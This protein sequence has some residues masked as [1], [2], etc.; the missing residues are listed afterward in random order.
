MPHYLLLLAAFCGLYAPTLRA[1]GLG[2]DAARASVNN[3]SITEF[4]AD[5]NPP[6]GLPDEEYVELYNPSDSTVSLVG[7][8]LGSGGR[9]VALRG[10]IAPRSYL[11]L[12]KPGAAPFFTRLGVE[13]LPIALPGLTNGGD[14]V[15]LIAFGDTLLSIDYTDTWYNDPERDR[16]G[17]SLEYT[18]LS[19]ADAGCSGRWKASNDPK[20][21]TPGAANSVLG[22][23]VDSTAP[24]VVSTNLTATHISVGFNEVLTTT[25]PDFLLL[26]GPNEVPILSIETYDGGQS[27]RLGVSDSIREGVFY[28]LIIPS[29]SDCAGNTS[30]ERTI[31]VGSPSSPRPGDVI[32]NELL[33]DPVT[34]GSD[35]LEL[36]NRTDKVFQINGWRLTNRQSVSNATRVVTTD[37]LFLPGEYLI[38]TEDPDDL[39][40][41]FTD[42]VPSF[43]VEQALPGLPN[44]G[45]N[46]TVTAAGVVLDAFDYSDDLHS[47]LL[48]DTDGVSLERL[49]TGVPTQSAANWFSAA[50]GVGGG[51]PTR[52]NSQDRPAA[53]PVE[54][55][56][57]S[58]V[59]T[60]FSPDGDGFEDLLEI[61][62]RAVAIGTVARV[63]IYDAQGRSV[64][65]LRDAE[66]LGTEGTMTWDG[67]DDDGLKARVGIYVVVVELSNPQG[68]AR[69]EKLVAVL[70]GDR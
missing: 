13:V 60:T 26:D 69:E 66:L 28:D 39:A 47:E 31:S 35:Y 6:V 58:V 10:Q 54:G 37:R 30:D 33:Y 23:A 61:R 65:T 18:E 52:P 7:V 17:Y 8:S 67:A 24:A 5:P 12:V 21:G 42:V 25:A 62:Y 57:L 22:V 16:G 49:R 32:I 9:P 45:G 29:V 46:I 53:L 3:L 2:P 27:F 64:R 15:S 56:T 55:G 4:M 70:A 36:Y 20:G 50:S 63:R 34:D 41:R 40:A 19:G 44:A 43:L 11:L 48:D 59:N 1:Q 38:F 68:P 51:T 14:N